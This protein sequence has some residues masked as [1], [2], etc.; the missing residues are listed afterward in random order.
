MSL[1]NLCHNSS[2]RDCAILQQ[3]LFTHWYPCPWY[4]LVVYLLYVPAHKSDM[5]TEY[6]DTHGIKTLPHPPYSPDLAS[7]NFR[8]NPVIK[9]CL[10]GK[11]FESYLVVGSSVFQC[12]NTIPQ[13]DYKAVFSKWIVT[14]KKCVDANGEFFEGL[15]LYIFRSHYIVGLNEPIL[16]TFQIPLL[17]I[18]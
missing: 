4:P 12:M 10:G 16:R 1:D 15:S 11:R 5:V 9:E 2:A 8:L 13:N 18:P 7:C 3:W 6:L 14:L 17:H